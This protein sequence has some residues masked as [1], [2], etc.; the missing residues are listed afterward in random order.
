VG[1]VI[2]AFGTAG[3]TSAGQTLLDVSAGRV[4]LDIVSASGTVTAQ[5]SDS[6]TLNLSTI[7]GRAISSFDFVGSGADPTQYGVTTTGLDLTNSTVGAAVIV[8]G[9]ANEFATASPNFTASAL[10]DPTTISAELVIDWSSGTAAPFTSF[11]STSIDLNVGNA[12]I[13]PRHQI[14]IG[15]Q[16]LNLVGLATDPV[17][18]PSS[19]AAAVFSIGHQVSSNIESFNTYDAFIAQLQSELNGTTLATGMT[20]VGQYAVSTS[21]FSASSITLFLNN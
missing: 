15:S 2:E 14:Q 12:G 10:L 17:I 9:F 5:G 6:L 21:A 20:A 16:I 18:S 4:R 7:G 8:S 13:G 1:S 19:G 3:T 11:D